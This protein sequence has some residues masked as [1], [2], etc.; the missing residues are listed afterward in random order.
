[1]WPRIRPRRRSH[2]VG[3][4]LRVNRSGLRI[5]SVTMHLGPTHTIVLWERKPR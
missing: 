3:K 4:L 1:M 2:R 5:N